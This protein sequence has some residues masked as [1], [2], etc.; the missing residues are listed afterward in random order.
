MDFR[1]WVQIMMIKTQT[2]QNKNRQTPTLLPSDLMTKYLGGAAQ[3]PVQVVIYLMG[4]IQMTI[5]EA[6]CP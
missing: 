5:T 3:H 6:G 1:I 4:G 2:K